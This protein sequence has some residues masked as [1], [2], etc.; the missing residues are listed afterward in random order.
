M[1]MTSHSASIAANYYFEK[2]FVS[3]SL[4]TIH[5]NAI[6]TTSWLK[7][8][9]LASCG[10]PSG[11]KQNSPSLSLFVLF[12]IFDHWLISLVELFVIFWFI[13]VNITASQVALSVDM[14]HST[15]FCYRVPGGLQITCTL[16]TCHTQDYFSLLIFHPAD[17][18]R[19]VYQEF[20]PSYD[21]FRR[22]C[23]G[24]FRPQVPCIPSLYC[25]IANSATLGYVKS[26][27]FL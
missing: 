17:P 7:F 15:E 18:H 10:F 20:H 26:M 12:E 13:L 27:I 21:I 23:Q 9:R 6:H 16:S 22:L 8:A 24:L 25:P 3:Y 11:R 19:E 5:T 4:R 1:T 14:L 2:F